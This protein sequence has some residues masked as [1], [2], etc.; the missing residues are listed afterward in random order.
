MTADRLWF[1]VGGKIDGL[2][3]LFNRSLPSFDLSGSQKAPSTQANRLLTTARFG[4]RNLER[5]AS[6]NEPKGGRNAINCFL[7]PRNFQSVQMRAATPMALR[8]R[9]S[10][11]REH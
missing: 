6:K 2:F 1:K 5:L 9:E 4:V 11:F 7:T 8:E 10:F 3:T